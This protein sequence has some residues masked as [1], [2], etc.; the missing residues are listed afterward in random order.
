MHNIIKIPPADLF[1]RFVD[2]KTFENI[3][4]TRFASDIQF[5]IKP[6]RICSRLM[7]IQFSEKTNKFFIGTESLHNEELRVI[8]EL[9]N[10]A[11]SWIENYLELTKI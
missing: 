4:V 5:A 1:G 9:I 6:D 7:Y 3:K 10:C 8:I 2:E 11:K